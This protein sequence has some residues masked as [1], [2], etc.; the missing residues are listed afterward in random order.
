[1]TTRIVY[2]VHIDWICWKY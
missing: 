2:L 1:M